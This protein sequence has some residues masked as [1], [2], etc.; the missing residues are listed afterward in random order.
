MAGDV[1]HDR[2]WI[3]LQEIIGGAGAR[4]GRDRITKCELIDYPELGMEAIQMITV[5]DF[6][7]FILIDDKGND[8]FLSMGG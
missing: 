8:F 7:V 6:P 2:L 5:R 3:A 4:L 1:A